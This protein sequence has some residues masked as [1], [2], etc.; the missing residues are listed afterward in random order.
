MADYSHLYY[1]DYPMFHVG[2]VDQWGEQGYF[3]CEETVYFFEEDR[4]C[5]S[6]RA[7]RPKSK[8]EF[9]AFAKEKKIKIPKDFLTLLTE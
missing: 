2:R 7:E 1:R 8:E 9:L 4:K 5:F 6:Y 3:L